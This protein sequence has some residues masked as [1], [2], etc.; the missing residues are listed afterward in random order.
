MTTAQTTGRLMI[1]LLSIV[2]ALA[3]WV[4]CL[5]MARQ[6]PAW[7]RSIVTLGGLGNLVAASAFAVAVWMAPA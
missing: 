1:G 6:S 7:V 4:V 3:V 5:N 2:I